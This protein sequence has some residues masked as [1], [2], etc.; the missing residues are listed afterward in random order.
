MK[1]AE[2]LFRQCCDKGD[3]EH[4]RKRL[5]KCQRLSC[6][7][8]IKGGSGKPFCRTPLFDSIQQNKKIVM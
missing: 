8:Q 7:F 4:Y 1:Y 3:A 2:L 6:S 5:F